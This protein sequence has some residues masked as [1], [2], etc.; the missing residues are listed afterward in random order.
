MQRNIALTVV[1]LAAASLTAPR[2][3]A[4]ATFTA[5]LS[6]ANEIPPVASPATGSAT[7]T[8]TGNI[9]TVDVFFSGLT[10]PPA[11]ALLQFAPAGKN[12]PAV[13]FLTSF[14]STTSGSYTA[15]NTFDL[16][17]TGTYAGSFVTVYGG[18][19][20]AG[21]ETALLADMFAG[22][23]Y[24]DIHDANFPGG[25]I[26]G[27]LSETQNNATPEPGTILLFGTGLL[28]MLGAA[29]RKW[30]SQPVPPPAP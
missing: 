25:E 21:A 11:A 22:N 10:A 8:L 18:G 16:T 30:L 13:V 14:P 28:G 3:R 19:T 12:G 24:I 6:G 17:L 4:D 27:Q 20:A 5:S 15:G 23:T 2:A 1:L 9:L 7:V 26:R 29:R